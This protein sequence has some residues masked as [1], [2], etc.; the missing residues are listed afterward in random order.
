[1]FKKVDPKQS[2]P[3]MEE[4]IL[5]YWEKNQIFEKSVD[6][7]K[8]REKY[9]FFDGPPFANGLPHYGHILA[10][11]LKDAVTRY[12]TMRGYYVPRTNGWDCHGLPVEYEIEKDLSLPAGRML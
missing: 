5:S 7:K 2:F 8:D 12:W 1:M 3:E 6:A 4:K 10:N 11:S 9:I